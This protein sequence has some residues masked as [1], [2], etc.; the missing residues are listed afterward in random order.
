MAGAAVTWASNAAAVATVS[1]SGLVTAVANGSAT[2][3]ATAGAASGSATVTV[4]QVVSAV[5]VAPDTATVLEGDTLRLAATATDANGLVVAEAEFVWAS[6]DTAVAVVDASGLV[7]GVG[8]GQA[9]V[10]ATAAGVTGGAT[11]TVVALTPADVTVTPDTVVLTALGQTVQLTAEVRDQTGRVMDAVQVTWSSADPTVAVVDSAGLVRAVGVG[12]ATITA[13]AGE[14]SGQALVT[15]VQSVDSVTVSP[16]ADTI[17]LG[18]TLR[19]VA[20]AYD[21]SGRVVERASWTWSSSNTAVATVDPSG[22]VRG[23]GEG[24][25]TITATAGNASATS[26][27]TVTN[28]DR[29]TLVALYNATNGPSWRNN[30]GWLSDAP[31]GEWYGV[32][33]DGSGRVTRLELGRFW[34]REANRWVGNGLSGPIPAALASLG[35]LTLLDLSGNAL[36]GP[37]PPKLGNLANLEQLSLHNNSLSGP[38]PVELRSL[39]S[40]TLLDLSNNPLSGPIPPELGSL[41]NLEQLSLGG[42]PLTGPIPPELGNLANLEQLSLFRS[43]LSGPIPPEIGNLSRLQF[44][45]IGRNRHTGSIPPELGRLTNLGYLNLSS[46]ALSGPVPP[47]L[48]QLRQLNTLY[49]G[50]N[51]A[52]CLPGTSAFVTWLAGVERQDVDDVNPCHANDVAVLRSLFELAGGNGWTNSQGWLGEGIPDDWYG[53]GVDSVGRVTVLDLTANGLAGQLPASLGAL[54]HLSTLK[55]GDNALTGRLPL[56]LATLSLR[57]F[58]YAG[59]QLCAPREDAFQAWLNTIPTHEGT[60]TLCVA[61]ASDREVLGVFY[62][63]TGGPNWTDNRNWLTDAPLGDWHGVWV[64]AQ[65]RVVALSLTRNNLTGSIPPEL[66]ELSSL[67]Y[68]DLG[69][70]ALTGPIPP[71]LGKLGSLVELRLMAN[72]LSGPL[73]AQLGRLTNLREMWMYSNDFT[74]IPPELGELAALELLYL[75]DNNLSGQIPPELGNLGSLELLYLSRNSLSGQIPPEFGKLDNLL[76][77]NV[78]DNR[79]TSLPPE[80]GDLGNLERLFLQENAFKGPIPPQLGRLTKLVWLLAAWNDFSGPIPPEL[81]SLAS[82]EA[83]SLENNKLTGAVPPQFGG[84]TSL[85]SLGLTNNVGMGGPLPN[86]LTALVRL[87]ELQA[88]ETALCAPADPDFQAWLTGVH[89]QRVSACTAMGETVAFL[90]QAIQSRD[91]PVPLVAGEKALLRVFPTTR[92]PAAVGIPAVRARFYVN[93]RETHVENIP[94]KSTPLPTEVDESSL[95]NSANAEIPGWVVQPGLEMVIEVDP[96]GSLDPALGVAKRI[97]ETGRV[98]VDVHEM[99]LFNLTLIPFIWSQTQDSSIVDLVTAM[100]ADPENH[101]VLR[102]TRTLMPINGIDVEAHD[103]VVSTSNHASRLLAQTQAIKVLEGGTRYYMGVMHPPLSSSAGGLAGRN[104]TAFCALGGGFCLAH[105]IGHNM[106]LSHAPCGNAGGPDPSFPSPAGA[107]GAWGYD[108]RDGGTLVRPATFDLMSYCQPW[109]ISDYHFSNALRFRLTGESAATAAVGTSLLL[110]GGIDAEGAPF[111]APAFVADAPASL[112]DS[113]GEHQITGRATGGGELFSL[114]FTMPP[115]ADGDGSS[116][117]AFALPVRAGWE[118]SLATITLSGPGGSVT[119]DGDSDI[120]MA[121]LRDP[122]TGQVRAFL[123]DAEDPLTVQA[124]AE[125]ALVPVG[126]LDVL[127]SRGIP[128]GAAWR[129]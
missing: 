84:M 53:V 81:G 123:R 8:A 111:L 9:E 10:T 52:I 28:P 34:D 6:G 119:L 86:A 1:A 44:L 46:N 112:P 125:G 80:I 93:G 40:L 104:L 62:N 68:L 98:A 21:E 107:I 57:E 108:F 94:G 12:V 110:W 102:D 117:F 3:T 48:V 25:T 22:L 96:E 35:S 101:E 5:N 91:W 50:N 23:T 47:S 36:S 45:A 4:T 90:T 95:S 92:Q 118:D 129:R 26:Q 51:P 11:L 56:S 72:Y 58:R 70:N 109:W 61:P 87:E 32:A 127:F 13:M 78:R 37:I 30:Q 19:L 74:G 66:G 122:Q 60:N 69:Q 120:P 115:T 116:S 43:D 64:D 97:P 83:L 24:R 114:S 49:L 65:N 105:E 39:T 59:T 15:V 77:L 76:Q 126:G 89:R 29:A 103:P 121:I 2:I 41:A 54:S 20:E 99:P 7:T 38:I 14:A 106:G 71:E 128:R 88:G 55:I 85:K 113:A 75:S 27:I 79:L 16:L 33:T 63:T 82:L 124:D 18:D 100:A 73:P 31:L 67:G 17:A 42:G